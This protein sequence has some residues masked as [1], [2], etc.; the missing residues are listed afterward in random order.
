MFESTPPHALLSVNE[1][2]RREESAVM[3]RRTA[4][5]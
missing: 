3:E 1:A 2:G 4:A 5:M